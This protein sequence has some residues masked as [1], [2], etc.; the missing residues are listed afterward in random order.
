MASYR[1]YFGAPVSFGSDISAVEFDSAKLALRI[2]DASVQLRELAEDYLELLDNLSLGQTWN[3][4]GVAD[5]SGGYV[6]E[7]PTG[8][9]I[10]TNYCAANPNSTGNPA[11]ISAEGS[12]IVADNNFDLFAVD[13]PPNKFGYFLAS[14]SSAFITNPG[15]SQG[16]LCIGSPLGR[17]QSQVQNSGP[18]GEIDAT[19]DVNNVPLLGAILAGETWYFQAW[20]RDNN[21]TSTSNFSDGLEVPFQ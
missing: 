21:P 10:G 15:G 18:Q 5:H 19:V 11:V 9:S 16:N 20:Y 7:Y 4:T 13:L 12:V 8:E 17:F 6:I 3:D 2:H 1:A 14:E